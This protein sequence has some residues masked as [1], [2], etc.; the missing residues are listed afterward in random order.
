MEVKNKDTSKGWRLKARE[1]DE[2]VSD[3]KME[4]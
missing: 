1:I 3:M 2:T 4:K